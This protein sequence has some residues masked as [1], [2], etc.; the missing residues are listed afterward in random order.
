VTHQET[1]RAIVR[2]TGTVQGV[3]FRAAAAREARRRGL[4]GWVRNERDGTV[5]I[6]VEGDPA[7]VDAFLGWCAVGQPAARVDGVETTPAAPVGY[8]EFRILRPERS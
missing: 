3:N 8:E 6:D 1:G 5:A 2:I 7:A 4:T